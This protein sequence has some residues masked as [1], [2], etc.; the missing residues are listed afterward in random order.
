MDDFRGDKED[1]FVGFCFHRALF[2]QIA[3][4]RNV[5]QHRGLRGA[6]RIGRLNTPADHDRTAIGHEHLGGSLL[7]SQDVV[8]VN[9]AARLGILHIDG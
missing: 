7:R 1:Q 5:T 8:A 4:P 6:D 3:Q 2:E 9:R